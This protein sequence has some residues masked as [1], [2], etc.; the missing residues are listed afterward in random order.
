MNK[1]KFG[2]LFVIV[3][4][5]VFLASILIGCQQNSQETEE[6]QQIL[7]EK[8]TLVP[9]EASQPSDTPEPS[10]TPTPIICPQET[11]DFQGFFS[12]ST[13]AMELSIDGEGNV[14]GLAWSGDSKL[15]AASRGSAVTIY[16][17]K[18]NKKV[19]EGHSGTIGGLSFSPDDSHLA[20]AS[21]DGTVRIWD[22]NTFTESAVLQTAPTVSLAWSPE[23]GQL[24]VG[25]NAGDIQ[26]WNTE[27]FDLERT[28][29]IP[30]ASSILNVVWTP[31]RNLIIA[32]TQSGTIYVWS[33]ESNE[34]VGVMENSGETIGQVNDLALHPDNEI[35]ASAHPDG[36]VRL[37]NMVD[38]ELILVIDAFEGETSSV[39]WSNDGCIGVTVGEGIFYFNPSN[40][41][42]F[43]SVG[44]VIY[45][46]GTSL[47]WSPNMKYL[48]I[49]DTSNWTSQIEGK[50]KLG[51]GRVMLWIASP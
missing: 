32:G 37:W 39:A 15:F 31:D 45:G 11:N 41:I 51:F 12:T 4:W 5:I 7:Q 25:T 6:A 13:D 3:A 26:V 14:S 34:L 33:P 36:K 47:A 10:N 48:V 8:D 44:S 18:L 35:L 2:Q 28:W 38:F 19:L 16:D 17:L 43:K 30:L 29:T 40:G 20:S 42:Q 50:D 49:G 1:H 22:I 21:E 24:V 27:T 9:L 46:I 23:G